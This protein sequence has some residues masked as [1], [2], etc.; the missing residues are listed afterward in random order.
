MN[1]NFYDIFDELPRQGPGD[2]I[3]TKKA[4]HTI[5]ALSPDPVIVD[6]GCGTGMQTMELA[7]ISFGTVTGIDNYEPYIAKLREKLKM[8]IL[9]IVRLK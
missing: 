4:Y 8:K 9:I 5:P 2:N 7:R 1:E 6:I 3:Y